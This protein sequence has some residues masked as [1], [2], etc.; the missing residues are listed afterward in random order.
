MEKRPA[1]S[2]GI[3][4]VQVIASISQELRSPCHPVVG[5]TD[6]LMGDPLAFFGAL[7]A[8]SLSVSKLSQNVSADW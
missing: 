1:A 7:S 4:Q 6:L 8:S 2:I 5:Y 3:E